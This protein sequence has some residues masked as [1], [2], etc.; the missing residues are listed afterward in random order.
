MSSKNKAEWAAPTLPE[1]LEVLAA[2][3]AA[4][5]DV[6]RWVL[7]F[8]G[9]LD[10]SLLLELCARLNL[11]QPLLAVHIDHQLQAVSRQWCDHCRDH[12]E[13]LGV[14]IQIVPVNPASSSE[15]SARSARYQA[16]EALLQPGDCLLMAQHADDQAETLLLRLL[17]G[18]GVAGLAAMPAGR[19]LGEARLLR[20]LLSQPRARLEAAAAELGLAPVEDPTNAQDH[21]DRNWL[22]L[23]ILPRLKQ[24]WPSLLQRCQDTTALMSDADQLLQER[25][26]EDLQH[27]RQA[28]GGLSLS[29]LCQLS[30]ARQRNL[31]HHWVV[32]QTGHRLSRQRL[33][34]LQRSMFS[35]RSDASPE[36][37]FPGYHLRRYRDELHFV[38]DPLPV[39]ASDSV[40]AV[41]VGQD[42]ELPTGRLSW[43]R[44]IAGLEEGRMLELRYRQ[45]G[46]RLRPVGRCGS[47][48]LKQLLQESGLPPWLRPL[49]PIL[50][51]DGEIRAVPG[52]CLCEPGLV[53]K[54]LVPHWHA[55]GLS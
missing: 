22:R 33:Q 18:S 7:A 29:Q 45:G 3:L 5:P 49:Q 28:S 1:L 6:R 46:E 17:R 21:Y 42:L 43:H 12:C 48:A 27:C 55:F 39:V 37:R 47:V 41:R 35:T 13:R 52:I 32:W 19:A 16:F 30:S 31:L 23:H 53:E 15:A 9:G 36:E 2:E 10:S 25:A 51:S 40:V 38:P 26:E 8:S 4:E 20:P 24:H 14:P 44:E 54:G 11:P 50:W 34:N